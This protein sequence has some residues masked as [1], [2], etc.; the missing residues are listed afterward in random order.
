MK[1]VFVSTIAVMLTIYP[2]LS[3][4]S[5]GISPATFKNLVGCWQGTL[6]YSGTIVRKPYTTSAALVVKQ[7]GESNKYVLLNIYTNDPN[8]NSSDTIAVSNDGKKINGATVKSTQQADDGS[9]M[10]IMEVAGF[11]HN[12]NKTAILRH[13]YTVGKNSYTYKK[14]IQL[15]GQTDWLEREV[16][17]YFRTDCK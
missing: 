13:S 9:L 1:R 11:D 16:F 2:A 6:N 17:K 15:Q 3:Q 10:I 14:D 12:N 4:N 7:I 5:P 8:D